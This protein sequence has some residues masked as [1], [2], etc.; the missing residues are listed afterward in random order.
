MSLNLP[1]SNWKYPLLGRLVQ[2]PVC[3]ESSAVVTVEVV[4]PNSECHLNHLEFFIHYLDK[5]AKLFARK[6]LYPLQERRVSNYMGLYTLN[7]A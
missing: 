2:Q 4:V 1:A 6:S 3:N 7:S 5:V